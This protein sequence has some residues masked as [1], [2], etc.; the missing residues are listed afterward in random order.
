MHCCKTGLVSAP[1]ERTA[2]PDSVRTGSSMTPV[3]AVL[4]MLCI[5][6]QCIPAGQS[7]P[8]PALLCLVPIMVGVA[9]AS[10]AELSFNWTGFLM[11]LLSNCTFGL[12]TVLSKQ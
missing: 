12:R 2:A 8:L 3:S 7:T 5:L 10:A 4:T 11:A 9:V 6:L 1:S